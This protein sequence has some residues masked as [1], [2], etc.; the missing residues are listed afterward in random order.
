MTKVR[1]GRS[2]PP[3]RNGRGTRAN[4]ARRASTPLQRSVATAL[5]DYFKTLDGEPTAGL[6]EL[7]MAEVER[8]LLEI[9]MAQVDHNQ[10]RAAALL[11]LNRGTLRKKLTQHGLLNG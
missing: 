9:V 1:S 11:G 8:P 7:V 3:Q 2:K 10:S 5:D 4:G 6:Y